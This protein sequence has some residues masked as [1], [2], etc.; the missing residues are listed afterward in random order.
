M[1]HNAHARSVARVAG[2]VLREQS[3]LVRGVTG[4]RDGLEVQHGVM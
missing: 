3:Y 2:A 4:R 1:A